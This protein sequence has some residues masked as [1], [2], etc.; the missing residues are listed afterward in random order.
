MK[1]ISL[2]VTDLYCMFCGAFPPFSHCRGTL[3]HRS[4]FYTS[5]YL[6]SIYS[7]AYILYIYILY[8][9]YIYGLCA[10]VLRSAPVYNPASWATLPV[11]SQDMGQAQCSSLKSV[12]VWEGFDLDTGYMVVI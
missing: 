5:I 2:H 11:V 8:I 4:L 12:L 9:L 6:Y 3:C 1:R 7:T 10:L